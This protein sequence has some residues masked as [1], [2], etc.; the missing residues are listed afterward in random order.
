MR[1]ISK[2]RLFA[3]AAALALMAASPVLAELAAWDQDRVT[4]IAK[5]LSAATDA[6]WQ[7]LRDQPEMGV[8]GSGDAQDGSSMVDEA[9]TLREQAQ[10]L[11]GHLA[12]GKGHDQ[13]RNLYRDL[14]EIVDDQEV[15]AQRAELD[16]PTMDAWAKVADGMRRLAP[17]YDPKA[18]G[19]TGRN[20]ATGR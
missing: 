12:N 9:R 20:D 4:S 3:S 16:E 14:K 15:Q 18:A 13:T 7:A 6:W 10:A 19:E 11:A 5:E 8:V 17:Y 2:S 1:R